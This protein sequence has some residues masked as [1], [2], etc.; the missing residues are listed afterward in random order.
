MLKLREWSANFGFFLLFVVES[1]PAFRNNFV[2]EFAKMGVHVEHNSTY[3]P[4]SQSGVERF[5]DFSERM[6][7][8]L[9][10]I[11]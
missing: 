9:Y 11:V 3:N 2:E 10:Q 6:L 4:P 1:G 7:E 5:Q 8:D